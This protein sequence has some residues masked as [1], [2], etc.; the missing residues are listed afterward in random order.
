MTERDRLPTLP[1]DTGP[2][3]LG[4]MLLPDDHYGYDLPGRRLAQV[5]VA[6]IVL[7]L[8]AVLA[9]FLPKAQVNGVP[10]CAVLVPLTAVALMAAMSLAAAGE[11]AA[12]VAPLLT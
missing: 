9:A 7:A 4:A 10:L 5:I 1:L 12:P 6:C 3:I 11:D 8:F 2:E